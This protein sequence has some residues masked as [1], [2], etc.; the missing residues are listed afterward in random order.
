MET[1]TISNISDNKPNMDRLELYLVDK[2]IK[3]DTHPNL[4]LYIWNYTEKVQ[5]KKLWDDLTIICRGL[6]TDFNGNIIARSF[7][8]FH[9]M[10]E[11]NELP[12]LDYTIF[13]KVDGSL[14]ILFNY[15]DEWIFC[16]RGSFKSEQALKG[17]AILENK[18]P[19]YINLDKNL[20]YI[21]EI[22]YPENKIVVNYGNKESLIYLSSFNTLGEEFMLYDNMKEFGFEIINII[23][24]NNSLKDLKELNIEGKEGFVV[25]FSNGYRI[26]IKFE[27]YKYLHKNLNNLNVKFIYESIREDKSTEELLTIIPDEFNDWYAKIRDYIDNR[28]EKLYKEIITIFTNS[29]DSDKRK[30]YINIK[31]SEY[32]S[33]LFGLHDKKD[34]KKIRYAIFNFIPLSELKELFDD[35][36]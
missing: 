5:F 17:R 12:N 26:K 8:K 2:K 10:E 21:F 14:G 6:V 9:N 33:V 11:V 32:K 35:I 7:S 3:R 34:N 25:R 4:P 29:Y 18:Y 13:E 19:Q 27:N 1:T 22:I 15:Q 31:F 28:Y 20:S 24:P 23:N 36:N 30:F 16:S